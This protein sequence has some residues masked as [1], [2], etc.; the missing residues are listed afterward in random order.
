MSDKKNARLKLT[1]NLLL[2]WLMRLV[3]GKLETVLVALKKS[4]AY[5]RETFF[6]PRPIVRNRVRNDGKEGID[7]DVQKKI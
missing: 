1:G 7:D 5:D 3:W 2:I 6:D 4:N